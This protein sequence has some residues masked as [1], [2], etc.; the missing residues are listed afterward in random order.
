MKPSLVPRSVSAEKIVDLKPRAS[1]SVIE[2]TFLADDIDQVCYFLNPETALKLISLAGFRVSS[3]EQIQAV[4]DDSGKS[5]LLK[6]GQFSE[7]IILIEIIPDDLEKVREALYEKFFALV[8]CLTPVE[9]VLSM[10]VL[11]EI[12]E[13]GS[14]TQE[15]E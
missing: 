6:K 13:A 5:W 1:F 4:R 10:G 11:Q 2:V 15:D 7:E 14:E 3:V 12:L 8:N 9:F